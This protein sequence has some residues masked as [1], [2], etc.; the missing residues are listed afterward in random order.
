M[1]ILTCLHYIV[2]IILKYGLNAIWDVNP[3]PRTRKAR[4]R[5]LDQRASSSKRTHVSHAAF[6]YTY[7]YKLIANLSKVIL[8]IYLEQKINKKSNTVCKI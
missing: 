6:K 3:G 2:K 1:Y 4:S 7:T 5:P 8:K